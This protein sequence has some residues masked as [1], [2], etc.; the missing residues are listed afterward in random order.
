MLTV[1]KITMA[2]T[3][4]YDKFVDNRQVDQIGKLIA[5]NHKNYIN[6]HRNT[7]GFGGPLRS[8]STYFL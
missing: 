6:I 8:I 3:K 7:I 2:C 1:D 5:D 4:D